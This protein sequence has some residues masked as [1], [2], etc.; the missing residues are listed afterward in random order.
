LPNG[1]SSGPRV[2]T[3]L[4]KVPLAWLRERYGMII[5]G[6]IDDTVILGD[7]LEE[8]SRH[9]ELAADLFQRLG[10]MVNFKK[11]VIQQVQ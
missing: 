1:L 5:S 8:V 11:S 7:S 10:F 3:K 4:L 6:Y 2:F 9:V